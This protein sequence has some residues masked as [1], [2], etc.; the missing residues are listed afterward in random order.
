MFLIRYCGQ[1]EHLAP[2][3]EVKDSN[4]STAFAEGLPINLRAMALHGVRKLQLSVGAAL[5]SPVHPASAEALAALPALALRA[6]DTARVLYLRT[7]DLS[8]FPGFDGFVFLPAPPT[9]LC[10]QVTTAQDLAKR[11]S[12]FRAGCT[13]MVDVYRRVWSAIASSEPPVTSF[14]I[15]DTG[16]KSGVP[17]G[18]LAATTD[19]T[20]RS[21][22]GVRVLL[23]LGQ[24]RSEV[25]SAWQIEISGSAREVVAQ[26]RCA[27]LPSHV[28]ECN[29]LCFSHRITSFLWRS[30]IGTIWRERW[31]SS[32]HASS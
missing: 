9:L 1:P 5:H 13:V 32:S 6:R 4:Y 30:P 28:E 29:V 10:I 25:T 8:T 27:P 20:W 2:C 22:L 26:V 23:L 15:A 7:G 12:K 19:A 17:L 3:V 18:F 24:K 11:M 14:T 21:T 16:R 31:G